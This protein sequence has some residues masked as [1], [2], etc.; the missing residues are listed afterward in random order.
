[1]NEVSGPLGLEETANGFAYVYTKLLQSSWVST[2]VGALHD[3]SRIHD[4]G[5]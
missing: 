2:E 4:F 1:M 3:P 5:N